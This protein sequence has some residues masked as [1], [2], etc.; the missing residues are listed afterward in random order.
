MH[1]VEEA[2]IGHVYDK[3][4]FH[5][6]DFGGDKG[7]KFYYTRAGG[8][9]EN[10]SEMMGTRNILRWFIPLPYYNRQFHQLVP[11]EGQKPD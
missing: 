5:K 6:I 2:T 9:L 4:R 11:Y 8:G 7:K 3:A 10:L 1:A